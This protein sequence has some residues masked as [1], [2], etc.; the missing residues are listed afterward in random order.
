M[1]QF[2]IIGYPL[3]SSFSK[4]YFSE[5]FE[6]ENIDACYDLFP[7]EHIDMFTQLI[8]QTDFS[9]MNVTI[10]H[11]QA[12]MPLL[13]E[14]DETASE[15]GAVNVIRFETT[16]DLQ[17]TKGYNTD[18]IGFENSLLPLLKPH[19]AK[20]LVLGTGGASKA[21]AYVLR[22]NKIEFSFVSRSVKEGQLTYADLTKKII[23]SN[24]LI[25]NTTPLGMY[26]VDSCPDIPYEYLN[27]KH[28]LYDLV[29]NPAKTIFL[30][31]GE[32]QGATIKNGLEMLYGQADAAWKIWN[33]IK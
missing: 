9:G 10:P 21:V 5:K 15:I 3:T 18:A 29:Y 26:P 27:E 14:L 19:H 16:S 25:V 13:D 12:V 32:E 28:L 31:K 23:E 24:T 33:S 4:N 8:S 1:K 22:K 7:L 2:G 20:A 6:K 30:V 11:K 17:R